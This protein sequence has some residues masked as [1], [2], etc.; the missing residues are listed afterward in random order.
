MV[1]PTYVATGAAV[2]AGVTAF[3]AKRSLRQMDED[4]KRTSD[5]HKVLRAEHNA[6]RLEVT[7]QQG[8]Y[9]AQD[10][11]LARHMDQ[12]EKKVW[13]GIDAIHDRLDKFNESNIREH[14]VI[15]ERLAKVEA[16]MLTLIN[17]G[18][19]A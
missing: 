5:K 18:K 14:G 17:G 11:V 7:R 1:D 3:L 9:E 12:E 6:L 16:G 8:R 19:K 2:L 15:G 13:P 4:H 10:S